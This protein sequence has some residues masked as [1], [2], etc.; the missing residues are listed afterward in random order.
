MAHMLSNDS[1]RFRKA[2]IF[3]T[4]RFVKTHALSLLGTTRLLSRS[5]GLKTHQE[6]GACLKAGTNCG[7]C[8]PEIKMLLKKAATTL[9][10]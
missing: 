1:T 5:E 3:T 9:N 7:S 6:V 4:L 10:W 2:C 8:V